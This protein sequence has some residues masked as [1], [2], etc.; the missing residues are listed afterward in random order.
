MRL[1][2]GGGNTG[3]YGLIKHNNVVGFWKEWFSKLTEDN[4]NNDYLTKNN[5]S[6]NIKFSWDDKFTTLRDFTGKN[7]TTYSVIAKKNRPFTVTYT[8][9]KNSTYDGKKIAKVEYT[10]EVLSS[11]SPSD[12]M[13]VEPAKNPT[14]SVS[15]YGDRGNP[16]YPTRVKITPKFYLEDGTKVI[17]TEDK[18]FMFSLLSLN[19]SF[20]DYAD[21]RVTDRTISNKIKEL[22]SDVMFSESEFGRFGYVHG[23]FEKKYNVK[24]NDRNKDGFYSKVRS[25]WEALEKP[26]FE[27]YKELEKE[28]YTKLEE[29]YG[30]REK[31]PSFY[32]E[33]VY[34]MENAEFIKLNGSYVDKHRDGIYSDK[35][36]DG[37]G[38]WD[39][40]TS[41]TKYL[42]AGVT[43]VTSDNFSLVFGGAVPVTQLFTLSTNGINDFISEEVPKYVEKVTPEPPVVNGPNEIEKFTKKRPEFN[44]IKP[45]AP[46]FKELNYKPKPPREMVIDPNDRDYIPKP[47]DVPDIYKV[48]EPKLSEVPLPN[49]ELLNIPK[50][51]L[52]E[53]LV[54][55]EK[56]FK[57]NAVKP[58][59]EL[60]KTIYEYV[61][62]SSASSLNVQRKVLKKLSSF[63]DSFIVRKFK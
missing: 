31:L 43:K 24:W 52:E 2:G 4:L 6:D 59:F 7:F 10:Y 58:T 44:E 28:A 20:R 1:I 57:N 13:V 3:G 26:L 18:P 16:D 51:K 21:G 62:T 45:V 36:I 41:K 54:Y 25:E 48:D 37:I 27:K 46:V 12:F 47:K 53:K 35:N 23:E 30:G 61:N 5:I 14:M 9:L 49:K 40:P 63:A 15:I 55:N 38:G 32:R 42:G 39:S 19:A 8:N 50:P 56:E 29:F 11:G 17:P 22:H 60:K 34:K 33:V